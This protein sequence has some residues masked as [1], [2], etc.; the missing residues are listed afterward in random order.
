MYVF[1]RVRSKQYE[2]NFCRPTTRQK[3]KS[4][5]FSLCVPFGCVWLKQCEGTSVDLF[6]SSFGFRSESRGGKGGKEGRE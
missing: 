1:A 6:V 2:K 5:S 3:K 4:Q